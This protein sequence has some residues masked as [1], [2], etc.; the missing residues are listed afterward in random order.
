MHCSFIK[1]L[2]IIYSSSII[3]IIIIIFSIIQKAC[4]SY[5]FHGGDW[6]VSQDF[7]A[8]LNVHVTNCHCKLNGQ[9]ISFIRFRKTRKHCIDGHF[10]LHGDTHVHEDM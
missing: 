10:E 3:I 8:L 7:D 9:C 6:R 4:A 5:S 1:A 2:I